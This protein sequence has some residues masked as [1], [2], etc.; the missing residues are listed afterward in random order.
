MTTWYR[1]LGAILV[2]AQMGCGDDSGT[3]PDMD[4]G[5]PGP[6]DAMAS[7]DA[8]PTTPPFDPDTTYEGEGEPCR[9]S[10]EC[11]GF[12]QICV[13]DSCTRHERYELSDLR[14]G[15]LRTSTLDT[16]RESTL[17][18]NAVWSWDEL[19]KANNIGGPDM[20]SARQ[21]WTPEGSA[22]GFFSAGIDR[23]Q[24]V[25]WSGSVRVVGVEGLG[26]STMNVSPDGHL[27]LAGL[28]T[29]TK[30]PR[31]VV[32]GPDGEEPLLNRELLS[33]LDTEISDALGADG[34]PVLPTSLLL[35]G[36]R[37]L[38]SLGV[39]TLA[40]ITE[41]IGSYLDQPG[42]DLTTTSRD[43]D[44]AGIVLVSVAMDGGDYRTEPVGGE[45]VLSGSYGWLVADES[46]PKALLQAEDP[47]PELYFP[48]QWARVLRSVDI[49]SGASQ[50]IFEGRGSMTELVQIGPDDT[51]IAV[52]PA[53]LEGASGPCG[54]Y[55]LGLDG[56][57]TMVP[58]PALEPLV[59]CSAT[60]GS[61]GGA[62]GLPAWTPHSLLPSAPD[63]FRTVWDVRSYEPTNQFTLYVFYSDSVLLDLPFDT[64]EFIANNT[65]DG[66]TR[67]RK[68]VEMLDRDAN[69]NLVVREVSLEAVGE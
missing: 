54:P 31:V 68:T 53:R 34:R 15:E 29:E 52:A 56:T 25:L 57:I 10:Y 62:M 30:R 38:V 21:L 4:G 28:D 44:Y 26:C 3:I 27:L 13:S 58:A 12:N 45:L 23:C 1:T 37:V 60:S 6:L 14:Y 11:G 39:D 59:D 64:T 16:I 46:G 19:Q 40:T 69:R 42:G 36:D 24:A 63:E 51:G 33:D 55:V 2:L 17:W 35:D 22:I 18:T 20:W 8:G 41:E 61:A 43:W 67:F 66:G 47:E 5:G 65:G 49:P 50:V 48:T 7:M 32:F 9:M